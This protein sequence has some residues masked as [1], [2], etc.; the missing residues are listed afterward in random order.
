[1]RPT[2]RQAGGVPVEATDLDGARARIIRLITDRG[3]P[4]IRHPHG[5]LFQHLLGTEQLLRSWGCA[6]STAL[7][8]LAHA[9]YGTDGFSPHL[10]ELEERHALEELAGAEVESLVYFYASCDRRFAYPQL[11]TAGPVAFRDRFRG[12]ILHLSTD[13]LRDFVDLTLA[14]EIEIAL[15][16]DDSPAPPWL[17][18]LFQQTQTRASDRVR[19]EAAALLK[20]D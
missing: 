2:T 20:V 6:E 4:S 12:E 14:N 5:T 13:A 17:L 10:L 3:A 9:V 8:G 11:G 15:P 19:R 16:A 1:M 7:G 18:Q